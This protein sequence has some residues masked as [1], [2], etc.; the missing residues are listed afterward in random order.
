MDVIDPVA[1]ILYHLQIIPAGKHK[2]PSI[3]KQIYSRAGMAHQ[4]IKFSFCFHGSAHMVMEAQRHPFSCTMFCQ[5]GQTASVGSN[6]KI[7]ELWTAAER[8]F[9]SVLHSF[10]GLAINY[11]RRATL[12]EKG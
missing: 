9:L 6:V 1:M 8:A 2:M 12:F 7:F 10:I 11:H 5:H 3:Q 4:Q